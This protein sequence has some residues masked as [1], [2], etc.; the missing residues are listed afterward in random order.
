MGYC[1]LYDFIFGLGVDMEA[2]TVEATFGPPGNE[3]TIA[4]W[5]WKGGSYLAMGPG[6]ELGWYT[7]VE[8]PLGDAGLFEVDKEGYIPAMSVSIARASDPDNPVVIYDP[9][10]QAWTGAYASQMGDLSKEDI[11]VTLQVDLSDNDAAFDAF[12]ALPERDKDGW[13]FDP[14]TRLGTKQY[15]R[16][17]KWAR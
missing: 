15:R 1:P 3:Q 14:A 6:T 4:L 7:K 9:G 5:G 17:K 12:Y 10:K 8:G 13:T 16:R 11:I 2:T